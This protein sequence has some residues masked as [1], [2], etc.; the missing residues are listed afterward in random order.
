MA[1]DVGSAAWR[2]LLT[3]SLVNIPDIHA[4]LKYALGAVAKLLGYRSIMG[5]PMLRE[6][7]AIGAITVMRSRVGAFADGQIDL[8]KTFA[9]QA[10]IAIENTRLF[11]ELHQSLSRQ[12]ATADVLKAISQSAFDLQRVFEVVCENA[13]SLCGADK[14]FLFRFDGEMLRSV[15]AKNASPELLDFVAKNPIK[16]GRHTATARAALL[17]QTVYIEDVANDP[18]FTYG[19]R[20]VDPLRTTLSVPILKGDELLGVLTIYRLEVKPFTQQQI[21]LVETFADQAAIAI[22]NVR[23]LTDLRDALQQQT[24]MADV[25]KAISRSTF[26]LGNVLSTLVQAAVRLCEAD[27]GTIARERDG[28]FV[29]VASHGF[30]PAFMASASR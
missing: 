1:P 13:L 9:D 23:L 6:G 15:V 22:E 27:Q 24:A 16:P 3:G 8:L 14:A 26:D 5:V 19:A 4:D 25:L 18:D 2:V 20:D 28:V 11:G 21:A 7:R 30:S 29:R 10:V 17:R 12:T